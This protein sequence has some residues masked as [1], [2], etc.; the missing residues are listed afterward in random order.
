M[1]LNFPNAPAAGDEFEDNGLTWVFDGTVW[2]AALVN[3]SSV[4]C[5]D[6]PPAAPSPGDLWF[7]SVGGQLYVSYDDGTS[8][9]W[10]IAVNS[11]G[12]GVSAPPYAV[13]IA[14]VAPPAPVP[15]DLWFDS[16]SGQLFISYD[17]GTSQQWVIAVNSGGGGDTSELLYALI[18][19][20]KTLTARIEQLEATR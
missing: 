20:V 5:A 7:D 1:A 4:V 14:D 10:V 18:N 11:G 2:N 9:Q 8:Q 17:D 13:T 3:G 16:V 19:S 15:G 12:G 6:A